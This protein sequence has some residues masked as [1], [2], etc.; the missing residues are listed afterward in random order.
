MLY[1]LPEKFSRLV[2]QWIVRIRFVIQEN[3]SINNRIDIQNR[4]PILPQDVQT[5]LPLKVDIWMINLGITV[6]LRRCVGIV[7]WYVKFEFVGGIL[8]KAGI[9]CYG[10]FEEGQIVGVGKFDVGYFSSIEFG[11]I[12]LN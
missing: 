7:I 4:F 10:N 2:V 3:Q 8:P 5:N 6:Y 11:N 12:F 9:R 1:V